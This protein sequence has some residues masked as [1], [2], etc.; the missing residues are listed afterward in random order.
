[1]EFNVVVNKLLVMKMHKLWAEL[2]HKRAL[3][4]GPP[5]CRAV[6]VNRVFMPRSPGCAYNTNAWCRYLIFR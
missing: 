3:A 4:Y 6:S 1:M 2:V 5:K